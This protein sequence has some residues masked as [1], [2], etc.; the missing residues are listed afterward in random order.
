GTR[1]DMSEDSPAPV[2]P[3]PVV[4]KPVVHKNKTVVRR[5]DVDTLFSINPDGSRNVIHP[6]D[7][8]GRFQRRKQLLW[9]V[10]IGIYMALPWLQIGGRPAFLID[11]PARHF[12]LFGY[13]F[14]AQDFWF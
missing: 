4:R 10:L 14:N 11:I 1:S 8:R 5:P 13:T 7:V 12:Y 2:A 9:V 3:D 6:A